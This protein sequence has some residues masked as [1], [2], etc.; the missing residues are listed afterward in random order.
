[1]LTDRAAECGRLDRLLLDVRG[2][3]VRC[4]HAARGRIDQRNDRKAALISSLNSCGCS[5]AE[6]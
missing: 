1:M 4:A 6:E 2:G 5:H 3:R